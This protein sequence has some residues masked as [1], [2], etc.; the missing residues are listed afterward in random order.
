MSSVNFISLACGCVAAAVAM[1]LS[2]A[3]MRSQSSSTRKRSCWCATRS[4][5]SSSASSAATS[6]PAGRVPAA[7]RVCKASTSAFR[8]WMSATPLPPASEAFRFTC[9][10][11]VETSCALAFTASSSSLRSSMSADL[12]LA[13]SSETADESFFSSEISSLSLSVVLSKAPCE[14]TSALLADFFAR[15][16]RSC[17]KRSKPAVSVVSCPRG[18][19]SA[20]DFSSCRRASVSPLL[21]PTVSTCSLRACTS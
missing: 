11:S 18:T 17:L 20:K 4:A 7:S 2:T 8:R 16:S 3:E 21:A 15:A 19:E 1:A 10:M 6:S 9:S 5:S 13:T 14:T 12:P